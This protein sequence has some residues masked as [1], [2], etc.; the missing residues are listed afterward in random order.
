MDALDECSDRTRA[1]LLI[2]FR[3][4]ATT[5]S[6][7]VTSRNVASIAQDFCGTKHIDIRASD[8]DVAKYIEGRIPLEPSLQTHVENDPTLRAVIVE[9]ITENAQGMLV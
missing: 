9:G 4:L 3:F 1:E 8:Q 6:L 7:L 5:V 2:A